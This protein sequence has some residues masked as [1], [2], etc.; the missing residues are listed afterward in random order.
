MASHSKISSE[1]SSPSSSIGSPK[2]KPA[3][4]FAPRP[5]TPSELEWL[6]REGSEFRAQFGQI[7]AAIVDGEAAERA[8]ARNDA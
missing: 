8:V 1:T 6:R 2:P 3:T 7:R 4:S 5:L